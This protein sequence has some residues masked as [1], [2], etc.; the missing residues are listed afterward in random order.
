MKR[1]RRFYLLSPSTKA[2]TREAQHTPVFSFFDW[3]HG[4][5]YG[6][7]PYLYISIAAWDRSSHGWHA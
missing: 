4:Y 6:R 3:L 1:K 2:F 5:A 7:W